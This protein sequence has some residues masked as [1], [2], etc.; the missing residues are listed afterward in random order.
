[1]NEQKVYSS[2]SEHSTRVKVDSWKKTVGITLPENLVEKAR[3]RNLNIS[4]I[5]EQALSSIL[6]YMEAQNIQN[7]SETSSVF[8]S[9]GSF[10]KESVVV[11]RAGFEPATTRSSASPPN[12]AALGRALSQAELPRHCFPCFLDD[13]KIWR[14]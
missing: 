2:K 11:P 14:A 9:T 3:K 12:V 1:M 13:L 10:Q 4:R 7:S 6:D 5:T 8:L